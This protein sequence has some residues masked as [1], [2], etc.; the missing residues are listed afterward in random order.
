VTARTSAPGLA[1]RRID[2]PPDDTPTPRAAGIS[3]R[4]VS[5]LLAPL[6]TVAYHLG[7]SVL[8]V[9]GHEQRPNREA[10][11]APATPA[12]PAPSAQS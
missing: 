1:E 9:L 8:R 12:I 10:A 2:V 4:I 7:I 5:V 6:L 3:D 11:T